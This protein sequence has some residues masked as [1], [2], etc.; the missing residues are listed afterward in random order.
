M[1]NPLTTTKLPPTPPSHYQQLAEQ[2]DQVWQ[3]TTDYTPWLTQQIQ[4]HLQLT[5]QE[6]WL[7]FG[8]G[9]GRFSLAIHQLAQP[10][11]TICVEPDQGMFTQLQQKTALHCLQG[12]DQDLLQQSLQYDAL[13]VKEVIH[14]LHDR[15]IFWRGVKSQLTT[16]G[17]ILLIT[18]P[19]RT[20]LALF[21]AAKQRFASQQPAIEQLIDELQQAGYHTQLN[22]IDY[23][24][25]HSKQHWYT[26][27]RARFM[28]D[29]AHFSQADIETG[30]CEL[31]QQYPGNQIHHSDQ[32]LFVLARPL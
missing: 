11:M 7:D 9:T 26:M 29:L 21:N 15:V 19:Q 17:R 20:P 5:H 13:L 12:C 2:F 31:D 24:I 22:I 25:H 3:F 28:S 16:Q 18:R 30:I 4:A 32:L 6:T 23:A 10:K 14:H 1:K 27:L 8:A